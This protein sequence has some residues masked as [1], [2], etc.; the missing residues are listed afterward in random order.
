LVQHVGLVNG[1]GWFTVFNATFNNISA[2]SRGSI[3]LVEE[4]GVPRENYQPAANKTKSLTNFYHIMLWWVQLAWAGFELTMLVVIG[5][6]FTGSC[7]SICHTI[8]AT[9]APILVQ[10]V[11]WVQ[12]C[13]TQQLLTH[14][15]Y[16]LVYIFKQQLLKLFF[17]G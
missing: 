8:T 15:N 11:G 14:S 2:I 4:S 7:K 6:D 16:S 12:F 13:I 10:T 5:T 3:L 1:L 9:T 17:W